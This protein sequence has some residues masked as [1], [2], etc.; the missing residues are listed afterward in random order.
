MPP[1]KAK[2][3]EGFFFSRISN[4][5]F[6]FYSEEKKEKKVTKKQIPEETKVT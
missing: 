3:K 4:I 2:A 6:T 1:K 5:L